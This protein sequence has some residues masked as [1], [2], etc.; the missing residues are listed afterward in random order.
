M[1][2]GGAQKA[3][4]EEARGGSG[5]PQARLEVGDHREGAR[6]GS[7]PCVAARTGKS[8]EKHVYWTC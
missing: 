4:T 3:V 2:G 6:V 8:T 1:R 7:G 5:F